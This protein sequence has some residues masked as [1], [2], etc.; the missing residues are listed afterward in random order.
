MVD[1]HVQ[2]KSSLVVN[3]GE[4]ILFHDIITSNITNDDHLECKTRLIDGS[5]NPFI[6]TSA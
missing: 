1:T 6:I 5:Y 3:E 2:D 4:T